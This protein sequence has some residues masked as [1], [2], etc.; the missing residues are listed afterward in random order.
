MEERIFK[1]ATIDTLRHPTLL[2]VLHWASALGILAAVALVLGR[3][4]FD[5]KALR[6]T[7]LTG[8]RSVGLLVL[9]ITAI[10][11]AAR[12][13]RIVV[14]ASTGAGFERLAAAAVHGLL[15][16]MLL[17]LPLLGW[18]LSGARGNTVS[19]FGSIDLPALVARNV[20][21]ADQ[22]GDAHE[23]LA[24]TMLGFAALHGAAALWHHFVRRDGVLKAMLPARAGA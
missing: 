20:D 19:L 7:L 3:D 6:A 18:A 22:L 8:H 2:I 17:V 13:R 10:R 4:L 14:P 5:E 21:L 16:L 15:Y 12:H 11:L 24:W 1:V 9:A 23:L